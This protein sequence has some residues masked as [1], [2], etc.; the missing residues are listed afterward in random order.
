M[1]IAKPLIASAVLIAVMAAVSVWALLKL[2]DTP[3][4]AHWA[5]DGRPDVYQ[6]PA[7]V[8]FLFPGAAAVISLLL[9]V[10]PGLMPWRGDLGRSRHA[11][12]AAWLAS[13]ALLLIMHLGLVAVAMGVQVDILRLA[14]IGAG[15]LVAVIGNYLPKTRYNYVMGIRTPWTLADERVWDR[16][17]RFAGICLVVAGGLAVLGGLLAP[18]D[19]LLVPVVLVPI[20]GAVI[21]SVVF[22]AVISSRVGSTGG[23]M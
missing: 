6:R 22:S 5:L 19:V 3:I 13:V 23:N 7:L 2:P 8:L 1:K 11:Y 12:E 20:L 9:A 14:V 18:A 16:T 4:P 10:L 15:A 17:H 21:A